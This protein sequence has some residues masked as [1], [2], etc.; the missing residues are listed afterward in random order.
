MCIRDRN[1]G[2]RNSEGEIVGFLHSDDIYANS[3]ILE[4]VAKIFN[5]DSSIDACYANLLYVKRLDTSKI[6]RYW[7]SN[8][9][10]KGSF[11]KGW[12]PPHPTFF[13]RRSIYEKLGNFS[14]ICLNS[15][16]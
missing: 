6:I 11:S 16:S 4:K 7:Q 10:L 14:A 2:I 5:D 12:S 3:N 13:V 9:F 1:K 8:E 15:S